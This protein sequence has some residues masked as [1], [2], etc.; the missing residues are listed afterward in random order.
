MFK[1]TDNLFCYVLD[2]VENKKIFCTRFLMLLPKKDNKFLKYLNKLSSS[3]TEEEQKELYNIK[4]T[5]FTL[6]YLVKK[7]HQL[8]QL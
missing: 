8:R 3:L 5:P 7:A 4:D 1:D 2:F 6:M